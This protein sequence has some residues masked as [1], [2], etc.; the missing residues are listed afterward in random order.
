MNSSI[1]QRWLE[2]PSTNIDKYII[3]SVYI[4]LSLSEFNF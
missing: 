3:I 2:S 1:L 4:L